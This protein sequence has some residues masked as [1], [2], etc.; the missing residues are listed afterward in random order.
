VSLNAVQGHLRASISGRAQR[1]GPFL[2][3]FEPDTAT[4][5]RNYAIPD[6]GA[7]PD[8]A[9]IAALVAH[10]EAL[11]RTPRLEYVRPAMKDETADE[12][13]DGTADG[14]AVDAVLSA[15][16]FVVENRYPLMIID[17]DDLVEPLSPA[18][19]DVRVATTDAEFWQAAGVQNTAYGEGPPT[20]HDVARLR[21]TV[22][23]GGAVALALSGDEP[24]G[25]GL[26]TMPAGGLTEIAAVGVAERYRR[27]G[28]AAAI[29]YRLSRAAL[30]VGAVPYLQ[31]EGE[32]EQRIYARLGYRTIGALT[33]TSRPA[34]TIMS[35]RTAPER[36]APEWLVLRPLTAAEAARI[37]AGD[38]SGWTAGDGWPHDDTRDGL[39]L[40]ASGARGWL[41]TLDG[42]VIGDC[43]T[44]GPVGADGTVE[45]G[46]GLAKPYRSRGYGGE[47]VRALSHWLVHQPGVREV[48]AT[49]D[50]G[51]VASRRALE[52]AGFRAGPHQ[53][54]PQIRY[55]LSEPQ[56][57]G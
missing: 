4:P 27:R 40:V 30:D 56:P 19:V 10:F 25:A 23:R 29:G 13:A 41:I 36:T 3:T 53:V 28:I 48:V 5:G 46:Y 11:R 26:F 15:A 55:A 32:A 31:A 54:D 14:T 7:T 22:R 37:A 45:I 43:G 1:V 6:D 8:A 42:V 38:L 33:A 44:T 21:H 51:N 16:G 20:E 34:G 50:A 18:G 49:V 47:A 35:E 52:R 39:A 17:P 57:H 12:T 9:E 2:V 24:V